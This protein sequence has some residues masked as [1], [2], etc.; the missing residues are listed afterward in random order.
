MHAPGLL[1]VRDARFR[2]HV[3]PREHPEAPAR[4]DAIDQ[5]IADLAN[6]WTEID[7]R[8]ATDDEIL[9]TH[10]HEHLKF[11]E[12][13]RG[14]RADID[15]DTY[16]STASVDV[17]KLAAGSTTELALR[18]AR[19]E[20]SNAF[21]LVRPPGHHA[22]RERAMGFCLL[23]S[24]AIAAHALRARLGLSRIAIVDWDV[25]HGN[26]TQ[27]IFEEDRDTFFVS[28]HQF[29]FYPGTGAINEAG[30]GNGEGSTLNLPLPAGCGDAEY[31]HLFRS[32]VRPALVA[33]RPEIILVSA[34]FDAHAD[35]PLGAMR[36]S[37]ATFGM[38]A[39]CLREIAD[40]ICDGKLVL[41]LEGGYDLVA[42]GESVSEVFR[43]L[44]EDPKPVEF[45]T[46]SHRAEEFERI[47]RT[48]NARYW[49]SF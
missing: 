13:L 47:F 36:V 6:D 22:E 17:A 4:L 11:L 34:G 30:R 46:P 29:P 24:V 10:G 26:G 39:R 42:L 1:I 37:S 15:A 23:N 33:F 40:E 2:D 8:S 28:L 41:S 25:H 27:H 3:A 9:L 7:P 14:Q 16:A 38:L 35:D 12:Q 18:V 48:T 44:I 21:A 43:A 31:I 32:V 5:A 19:G 20:G 45:P 49:D